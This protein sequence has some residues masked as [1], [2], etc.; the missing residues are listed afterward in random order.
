MLLCLTK[1]DDL[2]EVQE[3]LTKISEIL[4]CKIVYKNA[5]LIDDIEDIIE[6]VSVIF[7]NPNK[8]HINFTEDV[9]KRF[10]NLDVLC[11]AST[12]TIHVDLHAANR[13]NIEIIS[14]KEFKD[15][16]SNIPST[17]ELAFSLTMNGLRKIINSH[18]DVMRNLDWDFEKYIGKQIK[19]LSVAVIGYGRLGKI[20]SKMM[21]DAGASISIFDPRLSFNFEET[22]SNFRNN[23]SNYDVVSVHIHAE[24]NNGFVNSNFFDYLKSDVVIV[25]TSR[26]EVVE[27]ND[28]FKFLNKNPKATYCSDVIPNESSDIFRNDMINKFKSYDNVILT[29]HIGGMSTGARKTAFGLASGLL[30][31]H[32]I[33]E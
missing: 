9:L 3:N 2:P 8:S 1:I 17:A 11:T 26:G 22:L 16:L 25:N 21:Y 4:K 14:I 30:L 31:Q 7:M 15:I 23:A 29:Q 12:G 32:L 33:K 20:Y 27:H 19:D 5:P 13:L 10:V 6:K 28:L 18:N 24:G